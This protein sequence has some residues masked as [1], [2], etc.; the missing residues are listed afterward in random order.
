[1]TQNQQFDILT[2]LAATPPHEQPQQ[3]RE[4]EIREREEH[5]PMLPELTAAEIE[6]GNLVLEPL[7]P[8][9]F[10][11]ASLAFLEGTFFVFFNLGERAAIRFAI[12]PRQHPLPIA[13]NEA[14]NRAAILAQ[15]PI[16]GFLLELSQAP[17]F[18]GRRPFLPRL[19][20]TQSAAFVPAPLVIFLG[21]AADQLGVAARV[22]RIRRGRHRRWQ[23][24][25]DR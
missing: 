10:R 18:R 4:H 13:Q 23:A 16:G 14:R 11:S 17:P 19:E 25:G 8:W 3:R 6:N 9:A 22:S 12:P 20:H 24:E 5:P 21:S 1:V 7:T 2:E 15:R